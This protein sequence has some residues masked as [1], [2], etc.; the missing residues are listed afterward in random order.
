MSAPKGTLVSAQFPAP[1]SICS[2]GMGWL[3][4][5]VATKA[6]AQMLTASEESDLVCPSYN[7]SSNAVN[8][9]GKGRRGQFVAGGLV[10][11]HRGAGAGARSFADGIDD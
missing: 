2:I 11:D 3:V 5:T 1:V 9:F 8:V 6:V 4:V 10:S 7:A